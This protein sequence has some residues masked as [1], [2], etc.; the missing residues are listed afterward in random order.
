M[1]TVGRG[2][3]VITPKAWVEMDD[4]KALCDGVLFVA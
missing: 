1:I 4:F 2:K 3:P